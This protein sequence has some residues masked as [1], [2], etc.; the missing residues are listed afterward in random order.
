MYRWISIALA[1][2]LLVPLALAHGNEEHVM[3]TVTK[4]SVSS[5][6]VQT[7][8]NQTVQVAVNEKTKFDKSGQSATLHDL[9]VGDRVVIH[10][11]K[12]GNK[13]TAHT[14]KFGPAQST[15]LPGHSKQ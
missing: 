9:A 7:T 13:L 15:A 6:T 5:I 11:G 14:V 8:T 1:G 10:A 12:S 3:G 2:L 4:I